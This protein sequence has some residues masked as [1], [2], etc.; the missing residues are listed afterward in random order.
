VG[1]LKLHQ[2]N[3]FKRYSATT[4]ISVLLSWEIDKNDKYNLARNAANS[5]IIRVILAHHRVR[6]QSTRR[7]CECFGFRRKIQI[8]IVLQ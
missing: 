7:E 1:I 5:N 2:E 4:Q 3:G 8:S 6:I